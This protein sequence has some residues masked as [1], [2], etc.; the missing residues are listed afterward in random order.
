MERVFKAWVESP[1]GWIEIAAG[2]A[3]ITAIDFLREGDRRTPPEPEPG[4][5]SALGDC[6]AQ[7]GEY[8][9]GLRRVFDVP[10]H[11]GGTPFQRKAWEALLAI[12]FGKTATYK[13]IA[14]AVG[15]PNSTRAVGGANHRNPVSIIVPCH[16][17]IGSDGRLTG[18]GGGLWRKE[19]LL[20]HERRHAGY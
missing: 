6:A 13:D 18:Y 5:P 2:D 16:R 7:L 4:A 19:W 9:S 10:L 14:A 15:N 12:P 3:G 20:A 11:L 1:I 8:F 17:V